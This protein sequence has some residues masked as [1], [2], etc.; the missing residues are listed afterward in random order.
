[1][2]VVKMEVVKWSNGDKYERSLKREVEKSIEKIEKECK[3]REFP[4]GGLYVERN[5]H[6]IIENKSEEILNRNMIRRGYQNPF[7]EGKNYVNVINDQEKYL[8]PL[9]SNN[10]M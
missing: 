2:E 6:R 5:K 9:N 3:S 1:M 8:M 10:I 7:L 4:L